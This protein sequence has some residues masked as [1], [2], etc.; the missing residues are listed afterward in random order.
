MTKSSFSL[1]EP[2]IHQNYPK[3]C[4]EREL[5]HSWLF[6]VKKFFFRNFKFFELF[7][8]SG[9]M[10]F[11]RKAKSSFSLYEPKIHQNYPKWCLEREL[12]HSWLFQVK[13]SFFNNFKFFQLFCTMPAKSLGTL[14]SIS[15]VKTNHP[16]LPHGTMLVYYQ[17]G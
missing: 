6:Q 8:R 7:C 13:K 9:I 5:R 14:T 2:K 17:T 16:P 1:Y 12:R 10:K 3:W 15:K 11:F 4:L